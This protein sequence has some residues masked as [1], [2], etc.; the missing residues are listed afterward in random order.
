MTMRRSCGEVTGS[1]VPCDA[2]EPSTMGPASRDRDS[3]SRMAADSR[4]RTPASL[5]FLYEIQRKG[6]TEA[7]TQRYDHTY[8]NASRNQGSTDK[9]CSDVDTFAVIIIAV[10]RLPILTR[11]GNGEINRFS[12]RA[13]FP[14]GWR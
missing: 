7:T 12:R 11:H 6:S 2:R 9:R 5:V 10:Y 8:H 13:M 4:S 14:R 3:A 1:R